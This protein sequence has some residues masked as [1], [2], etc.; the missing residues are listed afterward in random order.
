MSTTKQNPAPAAK[1]F[2]KILHGNVKVAAL[3]LAQALRE[4]RKAAESDKQKE[5][6]RILTSNLEPFGIKLVEITDEKNW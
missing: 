5:I 4:L 6:A 2:S 1:S 3:N